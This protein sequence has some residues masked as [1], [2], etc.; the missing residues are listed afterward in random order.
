MEIHIDEN[1][2]LFVILLGVLT[3]LTVGY[4]L[5]WFIAYFRGHKNTLAIAAL[6]LVLGWTVI[7]WG[8]ALVWS[9]LR[10]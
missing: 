4:T 6:N 5:P 3:I 8:I 9:L 1:K 2:K 7:G 10:D